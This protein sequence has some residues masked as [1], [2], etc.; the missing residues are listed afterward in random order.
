MNR[1]TLAIAVFL[2]IVG[3]TA[4]VLAQFPTSGPA[5]QPALFTREAF[6]LAYGHELVAEF[7]RALRADADPAC[8]KAK[9][10]AVSQL[11]PRGEALMIKWGTRTMETARSY[12]DFG[13]YEK[14]FPA[15]A[16][17]KGLRE[18]PVVKRYLDIERPIRL[19]K[20][21]DFIFQ[22]FDR[23]VLLNRIKL[24]PVSPA[25]NDD[26]ARANPTEAAE[27]ALED[28]VKANKSP[29]IERFLAL[30][31]QATEA[32]Q[33]AVKQE[34]AG[35]AGPDTFYRGI[36]LDLAELCIGSRR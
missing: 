7:G 20:V 12:I 19:A 9:A 29:E 10:V 13:V 33:R 5:E 14:N 26:V 36:E 3:S 35:K 22:Q 17:L 31:E 18:Q 30:S 16:E 27:D 4:P 32:T 11:E 8:L 1:R 24:G 21:L 25:G 28:F 34:Q 2:I 23:Y 6:A 15:G